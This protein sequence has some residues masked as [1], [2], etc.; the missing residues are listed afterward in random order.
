MTARLPAH[1][2]ALQS[3]AISLEVLLEKYAKDGESTADQIFFRVSK[4][5]AKVET[6]EKRESSEQL[7]LWALN[8]GFVPA[9]RIMSAAGTD[10]EATLMNCFV[11]PVGDS[12]TGMSDDGLPGIYTALN[13]AAETMRRG[14]G[15]GYDF[16]RIRPKHALVKRTRSRASGPISYMRVFDRSCG[17]IESAGARRGAQMGV[18]RCDHPDI[19][20]FIVAKSGDDLKNFNISIGVTDEFMRAVESN[21]SFQ[22][23]HK[24]AP[25]PELVASTEGIFQRAD[26]LWVYKTVQAA[27]LWEKVM[28]STYDHAE[29]GIL[30]IDRMNTENNL[31]YCEIIEATNP[32]AEEPLPAYGC[33]DLGSLNL[34]HYI[35]GA[36][37]DS[38]SF[39]FEL[40]AKVAGVAIR[41]LDNVLD[42]TYWPLPQQKAES[43]S[44]RRVGLGFLG[45]G[46]ALIMLGLRYNSVEGRAFASRMSEVMRDAAINASID[47]SIEKGQFP[48][49]DAEKYLESGFNKRLPESLRARIRAHGMRNSHTLAI[50]PTG[51]IV[52]AF[53][54][55]AS[56]GIEPAF[57]W[58][59]NRTKVMKDGSKQVWE[60]ADHAFRVY[61]AMNPGATVDNLP[62]Q[63]VSAM[64]MTATEHMQMLEAVQPFIDTSISKTVNVP[65]DYPYDAFKNLYK[66]GWKA[67]LKGLATY[68]PRVGLASVLSLSTPAAAAPAPVAAPVVADID[69]LRV[70]FVK[71]P[72]G[73]LPAVNSKVEMF[74]QGN[75]KSFYLSVSFM[76]VDGIVGGEKVTIERP[77]EFLLLGGEHDQWLDFAMRNLSITARDGGSLALALENMSEVEWSKGQVRSGF[78]TKDDGTVYPVMH[79]SEVAALA[80]A[81]KG[82]LHKRGYLTQSGRQIPAAKLVAD[83]AAAATPAP[84]QA[85][86]FEAPSPVAAEVAPVAAHSHFAPG[87]GTKCTTCGA[88]D[89]HH[90]DGCT[91][92]VACGEVGACG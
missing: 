52:L 90:I 6:E 17:T 4:A 38:V 15:V 5:L 53:A 56:N 2:V 3:Q 80:F 43:D 82:I 77:V 40:F 24:A 72:A 62:A 67:G 59:Y 9:G 19:E 83:R 10:I 92:C 31:H 28:Q 66:D 20:E 13:E 73:D 42:A 34:T 54:D 7:F 21:G 8:N 60:V 55:N 63:F 49:F 69:P 78:A 41:M 81:I 25:H 37:T 26:G 47:L 76:D 84:V 86:L 18:L 75:K 46:D 87:T 45:L 68:R 1:Q 44:K 27:D 50:A 57:S 29:P 88:N 61:R 16:S 48:L 12:V 39:D 14:G 33:C 89:V 70:S 79:E 35:T 51:T 36:F 64:D 74:S 30:F 22:L 23:V 32:C 65:T 58:T 85:A 71:R 11:Q 91:K